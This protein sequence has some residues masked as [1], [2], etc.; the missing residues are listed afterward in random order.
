MVPAADAVV[1]DPKT[2]GLSKVYYNKG[3]CDSKKKKVG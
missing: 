2:E 1:I 3:K